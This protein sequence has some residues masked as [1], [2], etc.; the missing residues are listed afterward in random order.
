MKKLLLI[1]ISLCFILTA[2]GQPSGN[3]GQLTAIEKVQGDGKP[4]G[5]YEY[6]PQNYTS[7]QVYPLVLFL[8]G[9]GERGSG[10]LPDLNRVLRHGPM[11]RIGQAISNP[12]GGSGRHFPAIIIAPQTSSR[13]MPIL[14][15]QLID[16]LL[17]VGY[18][19]D[20][21]RIYVT[22]LSAGGGSVWKFGEAYPNLVAAMVPICGA[23][24]VADP[25]PHL[26]SVPIWAFHNFGDKVV[27]I[28]FTAQNVDRIAN[29]GGPTILREGYLY[30][31]TYPNPNDPNELGP[32]TTDQTFQFDGT[33]FSIASGVH[34]P[35]QNLAFTLYKAS[36]HNAWSAAYYND[37]MWAW[38]FAQ[39]KS[40]VVPNVPPVA[41]AGADIHITSPQNAVTLDG[42]GSLDS[43]GTITSYQW[44]LLS[45]PVSTSG[46]PILIN[47][48]Y[49][50][51]TILATAPW[52]NTLGQVSVG[53]TINNLVDDQNNPT[54]VTLHLLDAWSAKLSGLSTGNNSGVMPDAVIASTYW[55]RSRGVARKII[56]D[57]LAPNGLYDFTFYGG[58]NGTGNKTT[59]YTIGSQ[60]GILNAT[61]NT[62]QAVILNDVVADA[63]GE[64]LFE[65]DTANGAE[66][67]YLNGL[68]ISP[69]ASVV[70]LQTPQ[71]VTTMV[72]NL[73]VGTYVFELEVMDDQGATHTDQVS[74]TIANPS[75]RKSSQHS[76]VIKEDHVT[77]TVFPN[78]VETEVYLTNVASDI[79]QIIVIDISGKLMYQAN[80]AN[81][82]YKISM[83]DWKEGIYFIALMN[84]EK[85]VETKKI[86]KRGK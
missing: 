53:T 31:Y 18:P 25:S 29:V 83:A 79:E 41:D 45:G 40:V 42:T 65:V 6:L 21:S 5:Y 27:K 73:A 57:G 61:N 67:A 35:T 19:I 36:G 37:N 80:S 50:P 64:I 71:N 24:K 22:G 28:P 13:H 9:R 2:Y 82:N 15:E 48:S 49:T 58:R 47:F 59:R 77:A 17:N 70:S 51:N 86:I 60:S 78:P 39:S 14:L 43:D 10:Q 32:A 20:V 8:H 85:V 84:A 3:S 68:I 26:Q 11:K 46:N 69:K 44:R 1:L 38:L 66:Y 4:Y 34:S 75:M 72:N 30:P 52:N 54:G 63:S 76:I 33:S 56:V 62:T 7:G 16:Y 12:N 81:G 55:I 74:V 23:D